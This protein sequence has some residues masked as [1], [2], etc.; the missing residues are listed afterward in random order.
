MVKENKI[1][2]TGK[3]RRGRRG[4]GGEKRRRRREEGRVIC[5]AKTGIG[6]NTM[7]VLKPSQAL[8]TEEADAAQHH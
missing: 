6:E 4:G 1:L 5:K 3:R 2:R 7:N 8:S